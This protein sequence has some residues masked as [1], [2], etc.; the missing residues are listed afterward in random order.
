[1][2]S[3]ISACG[4]LCS[5]CPAYLGA[6]RGAMHQQRTADAW[7]RIYG[8]TETAADVSCGGC[9]SRDGDVF[10]TS[11]TCKARLCCRSKSFASCAECPVD[12]CPDLEKAQSAWDGVPGLLATLTPADFA[13]YALPYCGHRQ[14]LAEARA[15]W[16]GRPR[17]AD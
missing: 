15:A 2:T 11:R 8:L 4:V 16:R 5:E 6:A 17:S 13:E 9:L 7:R 14:R 3:S 12:S 10:R 1:M